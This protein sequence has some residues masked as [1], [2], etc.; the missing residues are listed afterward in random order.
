MFFLTLLEIY[1]LSGCNCQD[2]VFVT[3]SLAFKFALEE[4][5]DG[6]LNV[7]SSV[8]SAHFFFFFGVRCDYV[9]NT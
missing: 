2:F 7:S 5:G 3:C 9:V 6:N 1:E 8:F 4:H